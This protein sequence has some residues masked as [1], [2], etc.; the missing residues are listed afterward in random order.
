MI[1]LGFPNRFGNF[2]AT[3]QS[4]TL[5]SLARS[6]FKWLSEHT[7]VFWAICGAQSPSFNAANKLGVTVATQNIERRDLTISLRVNTQDTPESQEK[8]D[9]LYK[10]IIG[11]LDLLPEHIVESFADEAYT[12]RTKLIVGACMKKKGA[13]RVLRDLK[14]GIPPAE[15]IDCKAALDIIGG[16][17]EHSGEPQGDSIG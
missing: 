7:D 4:R 8:R 10:R 2:Y 11:D 3:V 16:R 5:R 12:T 9:S 17:I 13:A 6:R 14:A 15:G 1:E